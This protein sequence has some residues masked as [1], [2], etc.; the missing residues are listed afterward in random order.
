MSENMAETTIIT[1]AQLTQRL[2]RLVQLFEHHPD[3][4]V[5]AQVMELLAL[6]DAL[7]R[8]GL[9]RIV[10]NLAPER[11]EEL[12]HEPAVNTLL[13]LYDL[14]PLDPLEQVEMVLDG[15]RPYLNS[16]GGMVEALKVEDGVVHLRLGGS[17]NGCAASNQT[18]QRVIETA[19]REGFAG[20]QA[21]EVHEPAQPSNKRFLPVISA[22]QAAKLNKPVFTAVGT[23]EIVPPGTLKGVEV[24]GTRVLLCNIAGEIY[25]YQNACPGSLL[26]L[27]VAQLQGTSLLCPWHSCVFDARSGKRLDNQQAGRLAVI[28]VAIRDGQIQLALNVAPVAAGR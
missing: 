13:T 19:L 17:C 22:T 26:P 25:A 14:A 15:V 27:D 6:V 10:E 9:G 1:L 23:P 4:Q 8:G 28:P 16:H 20:F 24:A 18:L 3:E 21:I 7:H 2:D 11:Y 5:R 12:L